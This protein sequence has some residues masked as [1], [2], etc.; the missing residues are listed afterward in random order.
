M[1]NMKQDF[2]KFWVVSVNNY[3]CDAAYSG[4]EL[5]EKHKMASFRKF[6]FIKSWEDLKYF[7]K[8]ES[9]TDNV[10]LVKQMLNPIH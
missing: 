4:K 3:I 5:K 10:E 1:K 2:K 7:S 6:Y 9:H 8:R